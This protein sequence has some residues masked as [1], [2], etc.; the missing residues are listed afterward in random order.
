MNP[1]L[2]VQ[3]R[4]SKMLAFGFTLT[5][6]PLYGIGSLIALVIGLKGRRVV[7]RANGELSGS[8]MA[9]WCIIAGAVGTLYGALFWFFLILVW[10]G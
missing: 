2:E 8:V 5:L 4:T 10:Q 7:K 6:I 9:W 3:V 1:A